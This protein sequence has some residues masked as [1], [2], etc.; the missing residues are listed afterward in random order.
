MQMVPLKQFPTDFVTARSNPKAVIVGFW[1][2]FFMPAT[3]VSEF[4]RAKLETH[5]DVPLRCSQPANRRRDDNLLKIGT[6]PIRPW[7]G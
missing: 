4:R 3:P 5:P 6:I 7:I 1:Y 2:V